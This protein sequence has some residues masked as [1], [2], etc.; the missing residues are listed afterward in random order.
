[1]QAENKRQWEKNVN[2]Y[3]YDITPIKLHVVVVQNNC[4]EMYKKVY[5]KV[6][7]FFLMKHIVVF[8]RSPALNITRVYIFLNKL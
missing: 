5:C 4:K 7:C 1:M 2:M 6:F 8:H 3:M